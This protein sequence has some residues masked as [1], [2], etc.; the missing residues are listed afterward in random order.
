MTGTDPFDQAK[1]CLSNAQ[2]AKGS[3]IWGL[4]IVFSELCQILKKYKRCL[5]EDILKPKLYVVTAGP[6][7]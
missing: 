7:H 3:V 5:S 4:S 2:R 6:L 1:T